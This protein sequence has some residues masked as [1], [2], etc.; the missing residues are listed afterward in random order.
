MLRV[1][2]E[3]QLAREKRPDLWKRTEQVARIIDPGAFEDGETLVTPASAR[4]LYR[5]RLAYQQAIA[6]QRAHEVLTFLGVNTATEWM[7][8]LMQLPERLPVEAPS[9]E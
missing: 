5:T 4:K 8:I 2:T 6:L 1:D 7:D 3:I 9:H